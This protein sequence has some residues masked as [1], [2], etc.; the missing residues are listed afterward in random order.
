MIVGGVGSGRIGPVT[1]VEPAF[2]GPCLYTGSS[3]PKPHKPAEQQFLLDLLHQ[4]PLRADREKNPGQAGP[5]PQLRC[6][7]RAAELGVES[8]KL[9]T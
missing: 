3:M 6:D 9:G 1:T 2:A 7:R 8:L 5:D 4:L